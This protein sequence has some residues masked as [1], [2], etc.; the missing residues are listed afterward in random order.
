MT[1]STNSITATVSSTSSG[2]SVPNF[3]VVFSILSNDCINPSIDVEFEEID[4]SLSNSEYFDVL[5]GNESVIATCTGG[6]DA[7]CN[8]WETCVNDTSLGIEKID[9]NTNYTITIE[10]GNGF[11]QLCT[12]SHY[13]SFHAKVTLNCKC[14]YPIT[15]SSTMKPTTMNSTTA[16]PTTTS[17]LEGNLINAIYIPS[18][19]MSPTLSS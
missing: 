18:I 10:T 3:D 9:A 1:P 13:L 4:Y 5:D 15:S 12:S 11:N 16:N 2:S 14:G 8:S 7:N 6:G 19:Y 17:N